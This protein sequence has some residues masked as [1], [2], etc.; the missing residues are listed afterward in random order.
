MSDTP[1]SDKIT[2]FRALPNRYEFRVGARRTALSFDERYLY[3]DWE[4]GMIS[5]TR[6]HLLCRLSPRVSVIR[7]F[8]ALAER[9]IKIGGALL[10]MAV[11]VFFSEYRGRLPLL[12]PA[13][14]GVGIGPF[15]LGAR[16][17]LPK[18]WLNIDDEMG[19]N[20]ISVELKPNETAAEVDS[21]RIFERNLTEAIEKAKQAEYYE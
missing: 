4:T 19:T 10:L 15:V 2:D 11:V 5:G 8:D 12:A 14:F 16:N 18:L 13:L 17:I 9:R 6:C 20:E 1:K 7:S 3:E 21:R